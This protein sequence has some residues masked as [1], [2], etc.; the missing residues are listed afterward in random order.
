MGADKIGQESGWEKAFGR[1]QIG[2]C[3][4]STG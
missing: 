4:W 3:E 1:E 2:A